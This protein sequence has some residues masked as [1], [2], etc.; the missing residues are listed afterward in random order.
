VKLPAAADTEVLGRVWLKGQA[1]DTP[2]GVRLGRLAELL[3][4]RPEAAHHALGDALTTAQAFVALA[5]HLDR[6]H[7][8]TV[9]SL[10]RASERQAGGGRFALG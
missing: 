6:E 10:L 2:R 8:Q 5:T 9:G 7:P 1:N 3:G 4:Q